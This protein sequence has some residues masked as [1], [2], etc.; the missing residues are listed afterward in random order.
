VGENSIL[1]AQVGVSG[2]SKLGRH[3]TLAGQV[4][5]AGHI[6][7]GDNTTLAAQAGV[8]NDIPANEVYLWS[9]AIRA[10]DAK[11]CIAAV[12][13]LPETR[14]TIKELLQRVAALEKKLGIS[15]EPKE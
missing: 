6:T 13:R 10:D 1:V 9:P 3:V 11:R 2:S 4:G 5:V 14:E 12:F 7:I 15:R 8:T